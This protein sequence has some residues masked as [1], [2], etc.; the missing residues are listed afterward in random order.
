MQPSLGTCFQKSW[1]LPGSKS[2]F[3]FSVFTPE[4]E[5]FKKYNKLSR[6]EP[7]SPNTP[8][9][10]KNTHL[11]PLSIV[12]ICSRVHLFSRVLISVS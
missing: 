5:G 8:D 11:V 4:N 3:M 9:P 6:N 2:Y 7:A 1:L 12:F 10:F